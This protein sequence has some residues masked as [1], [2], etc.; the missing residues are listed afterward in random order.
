MTDLENY[1]YWMRELEA[2]DGGF[3]PTIDEPAHQRRDDAELPLDGF[4]RISAAKTKPDAPV[5]IW[6][7]EDGVTW[8]KIGRRK[9]FP[10]TGDEWQEFITGASW[11]KCRAVTE[12]QYRQALDS[13]MWFD[14]KPSRQLSIE[15]ELGLPKPGENSQAPEHEALRDVIEAAVEK[16]DALQVTTQEEADLAVALID[17]LAKLFKYG[18]DK[19][20][21]LK[22]PHDEAATQIQQTWL[23]VINPAE[24]ARVSLRKRKDQFLVAEQARLNKIA[25]DEE[26]ARLAALPKT[27]PGA[28]P[29]YTAPVKAEK[30]SAG[31][32][33]G[34][35]SSVRMKWVGEITDQGALLAHLVANK[36]ADLVALLQ[37]RADAAARAFKSE[38]PIP[39]VKGHHVPAI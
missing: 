12:D 30:A 7:A 24:A 2:I 21:E 9:E 15:E 16:A 20:A 10:S 35:A 11:L 14:N 13:G 8:C 32:A 34:R 38:T 25:A 5:A 28:E 33:T 27:E 37:N 29:V 6:T 26:A 23:P 3:V 17:K 39:G 4:W 36:D 19:R 1:T 22:R 18:D 31:G